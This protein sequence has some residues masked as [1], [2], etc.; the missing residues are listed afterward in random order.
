MPD[1]STESAA[2]AE[3][4][5]PVRCARRRPTA[6]PWPA[7]RRSRWRA[8]VRSRSRAGCPSPSANA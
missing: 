3:D 6:D 2:R 8:E 7:E 4:H 5:A 1:V